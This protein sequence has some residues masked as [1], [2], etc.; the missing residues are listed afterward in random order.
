MRITPT[1]TQ[2]LHNKKSDDLQENCL[3]RQLS[4]GPEAHL[5]RTPGSP[6][7]SAFTLFAAQ[8]P[9]SPER[10]EGEQGI[11]PTGQ[12][13][14]SDIIQILVRLRAYYHTELILTTL[15]AYLL[16]P[17]RVIT[18]KQDNSSYE[19]NCASQIPKEISTSK[20][21]PSDAHSRKHCCRSGLSGMPRFFR[22]VSLSKPI[23]SNFIQ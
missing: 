1:I 13:P 12:H 19:F 9:R 14:F 11:S 20:T 21:C 2:K 22:L 18:K 3:T 6:S 16:T 17:Y 7:R 10:S 23:L 4:G 15:I 5:S 8:L